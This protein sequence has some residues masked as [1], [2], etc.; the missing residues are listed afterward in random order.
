MSRQSSLKAQIFQQCLAIDR[1]A[2][3]HLLKKPSGKYSETLEKAI[4]ES[5]AMREQRILRRPHSNFNTELP[6]ANHVD[7]LSAAI[8]HNQVVIVCGETGSGKT[9]Q[10]PQLCIDLGLADAGVIGHTQP[11]RIAAQTVCSRIADEL[12]TEPG[13]AVGYKIRFQDRSSDTAYIK[14]MTDGI[15]LAETQA[16]RWLSRYSCLIIDEAHERSLNIDLLLGFI[17]QLL[18]R[19]PDLKLIVTSAT[20]DPDRFASY[21]SDAP[22]VN[23]SGRGYAVDLRYRGTD[24]DDRDNLQ[25]LCDAVEELDA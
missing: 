16:D 18:P 21:F 3:L 4:A 24:N 5:T 13:A 8:L 23:I 17:K 12:K 1:S 2:L 19:R 14:L 20:I 25:L 10:L 6:F 15:L 11:R 22:I 7:E 9:T